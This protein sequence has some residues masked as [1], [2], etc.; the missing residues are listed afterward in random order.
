MPPRSE[1]SVFGR[2]RQRFVAQTLASS[3]RHSLFPDGRMQALFESFG[4]EFARE[5]GREPTAF[6]KELSACGIDRGGK[7]PL[8]A[9]TVPLVWDRA[10]LYVSHPRQK[11]LAWVLRQAVDDAFDPEI[12]PEELV[13]WIGEFFAAEIDAVN[14]SPASA[15]R[16]GLRMYRSRTERSW[17]NFVR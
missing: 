1:T 2:D 14:G 7:P 11:A 3:A 8:V 13:D 17:A 16:D 9:Y 6:W 4:R 5:N 10:D 12:A 15:F